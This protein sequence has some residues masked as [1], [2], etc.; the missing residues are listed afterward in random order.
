MKKESFKVI[1][2][3]LVPKVVSLI[4]EREQL[5]EIHACMEFYN[6]NLYARL[7]EEENNLYQ[8]GAGELY[9][10]WHEEGLVKAG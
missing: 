8:L 4:M 5:D 6:S 1:M 10:L 9:E 2:I 7:E 3:L